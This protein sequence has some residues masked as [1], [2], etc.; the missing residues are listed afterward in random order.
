MTQNPPQD[1]EAAGWLSTLG[2]TS[3]CQWDVLVFLYRHQTTLLGAADLARLLGYPSNSIVVALDVLEVLTLVARSRVSQGAR[4]YQFSVP[5]DSPRG[6]A[7][8]RLQ[9]LTAHRAGRIRVAQQLRLD[10]THEET[11]QAA[12]RFLADA[13]QR[14]QVVRQQAQ[15]REER[16]KTWRKAI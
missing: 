5:L 8:A 14:L 12:Q 16:R 13:Q 11:L 6:A 1:P 7:F 4:L 3:L 2:V 15:Q 9:A 10:R